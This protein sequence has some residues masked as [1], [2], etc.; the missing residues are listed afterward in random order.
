MTSTREL[1][2]RL[3]ALSYPDRLKILGDLNLLNET[4][5]GVSDG[6]L[7]QRAIRRAQK[8]IKQLTRLEAAINATTPKE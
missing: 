7:I 3:F 4:D 1:T 2:F 8:D 5:N 6:E